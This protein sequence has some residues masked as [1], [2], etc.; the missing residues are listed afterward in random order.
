MCNTISPRDIPHCIGSGFRR[1]DKKAH[2]IF[3]DAS[4]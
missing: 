2:A 4:S 3:G 1:S